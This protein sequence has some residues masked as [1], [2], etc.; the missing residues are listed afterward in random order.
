MSVVQV[1]NHTELAFVQP[2]T[3]Q[4]RVQSEGGDITLDGFL[5]VAFEVVHEAHDP[6]V[7]VLTGVLSDQAALNSMLNALFA[8]KFSIWSVQRLD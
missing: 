4:V 6:E 2:A 8:R 5:G 7:I 1:G 3:Y